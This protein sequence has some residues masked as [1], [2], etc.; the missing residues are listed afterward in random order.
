[1]RDTHSKY[2]HAAVC[3][4]SSAKKHFMPALGGSFSPPRGGGGGFLTHVRIPQQCVCESRAH[5]AVS[6]IEEYVDVSKRGAQNRDV[7]HLT[8]SPLLLPF[9]AYIERNTP[10]AIATTTALPRRRL[11]SGTIAWRW[12][13]QH[14]C[15]GR[16]QYDLAAFEQDCIA[17]AAA[18]ARDVVVG[19][20][21]AK[22]GIPQRD[23]Y[24]CALQKLFEARDGPLA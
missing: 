7:K 13:A 15:D 16:I 19:F 23:N 5:A 20:C 11:L 14:V 1:M 24:V 3:T 18:A 22:R 21:G 9:P 4:A 8:T 12:Q 10:V 6:G 2:S 17:C